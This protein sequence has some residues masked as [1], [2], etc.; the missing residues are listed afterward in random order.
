MVMSCQQNGQ[1]YNLWMAYMSFGNM[2]KFKCLGTIVTYQN[3][4]HE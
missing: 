4:I 3:G 2:A 1:N